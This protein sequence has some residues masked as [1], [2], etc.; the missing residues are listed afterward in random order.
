MDGYIAKSIRLCDQNESP[1]PCSAAGATTIAAEAAQGSAIGHFSADWS[2]VE[3][4]LGG[5]R[6]LLGEVMAAFMAEGPELVAAMRLAVEARNGLALKQAAHTLK[7]TLQIFHAQSRQELACELDHL[8]CKG[9]FPAAAGVLSRLESALNDF[10][11]QMQA[12]LLGTG[13]SVS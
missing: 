9:D 6:R 5:D 12:Y 10:Y 1:Q 11:R 13:Q 3:S 7:G 8:A 2:V 4:E